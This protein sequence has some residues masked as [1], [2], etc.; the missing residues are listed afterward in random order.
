VHFKIVV[1][2]RNVS[3]YIK[4][5]LESILNQ[6]YI[7][8][9]IICVDDASEDVEEF[10][11]IVAP[12]LEKY[13]EKIKVIYNTERLYPLQN[14]VKAIAAFCRNSE[15][16]VVTVDADDTL[17]SKNSLRRL[18]EV[19]KS[20]EVWMTYGNYASESNGEIR[21]VHEIEGDLDRR[22]KNCY[23]SHLR[24]FKK[25]VYD[26]I[27]LEDFLDVDGDYFKVAA[28]LVLMFPIMEMSG[29]AHVRYIPDPL[30][31]YNDLNTYGESKLFLSEQVRV[32]NLLR[33]RERYQKV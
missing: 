11:E 5:C 20:G 23:I 21:K 27:E 1:C 8:Y 13:P 15:D 12:Y 10:K 17:F 9:Q 16:V 29:R 24:T 4:R 32:D 25:H 2:G 26:K 28:D 22:N 19:Y 33:L 14:H 6:T 30:L 7:D 31:L 18:C 3:L